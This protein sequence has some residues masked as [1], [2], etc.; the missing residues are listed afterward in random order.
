[1]RIIAKRTLREFWEEHPD[2][3][4][5]LLDWYDVAVLQDWRSPNDVKQTYGSASI[6]ESNRVIF[7]IKGNDY[8]LI[9]HIDYLFGMVFI[10]WIGTHKQYDKV[11]ARTIEFKRK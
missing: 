4:Q 7:N 9:T 1:M 2:A 3:E 10:L 5:P 6:I 8:R 11:N